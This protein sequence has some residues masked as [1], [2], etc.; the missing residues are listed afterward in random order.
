MS[1]PFGSACTFVAS[2]AAVVL[3]LLEPSP[4]SAVTRTCTSDAV[5]NTANVLC[6]SPSG[7]CN[8]TSVTVSTAIDVTGGGC[9]FDLQGRMLRFEKT[10]QMTGLGFIKV[11]NAGNITVTSTGKL[12]ARGDFVQPNGY[13]IGGGLISLESSGTISHDGIID[14]AGDPAGTIRLESVGTITL[15]SGS[16]V[17]A[18]GVTSF[19][20]DGTRTTDG[21][22]VELVSSADSVA[23][24]GTLEARGT[25]GGIGGSILLQAAKNVSVSKLIDASGGAGDGGDVAL[26]T[27]DNVTMT[28][29][30]DVDSRGGGGFGGSITIYSGQDDLGGVG[31]GG[32][33]TLTSVALQLSGSSGDTFGGDGGE[34]DLFAQGTLQVTGTSV[35]RANAGTNFDGSGGLVS[36]QTGDDDPTVVGPL[37]GVLSVAGSITAGS[38]GTG[39]RGGAIS[40]ISGSSLT[41]TASIDV[42]GKDAGGDVGG[43]AGS[44]ITLDGAIDAKATNTAGEGGFVA[45]TAGLAQD[46]TLTVKKNVTATG[47]ATN[48]E[49][50]SITFT[51]C[52]VTIDTGTHINGTGGTTGGGV[53][54]GSVIDLIA[55]RTLRLKSASDYDAPPAGIIRLTHPSSQT[56]IIESGVT[57]NPSYTDNPIASGP[58]PA[59]PTSTATPT[60]TRTATPTRTPTPTATP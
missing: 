18:N 33:I 8:G 54:G 39:G 37:D 48:G 3:T 26:V 51:G 15:Q 28:N 20:L 58:Y 59:C 12:K 36:F 50:Q 44:S 4:A 22:E 41:V 2:L 7:P 35:I 27:G 40:F 43:E 6:A 13:I 23:M 25:Q 30:I 14:V 52:N 49:G 46:G 34:L 9:A 29:D 53:Q 47:G 45:F 55:L 24:G 5:A 16:S 10:F 56:P 11:V 57:F 19:T 1:H 21:G 31:A 17:T 38:G 42:N 32:N 60:P